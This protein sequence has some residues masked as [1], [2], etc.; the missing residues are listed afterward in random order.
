MFTKEFGEQKAVSYKTNAT[1]LSNINTYVI[2]GGSAGGSG[3]STGGGGGTAGGSG[4]A[5]GGGATGGGA[6]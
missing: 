4:G 2:S 6:K 1:I 3:G 5:T